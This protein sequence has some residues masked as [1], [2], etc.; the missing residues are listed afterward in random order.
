MNN[1]T[2]Y[3]TMTRN[4][5]RDLQNERQC[6]P[7]WHLIH[8]AALIERARSGAMSM[9]VERGGDE[10]PDAIVSLGGK[11][12]PLEAKLLTRCEEEERFARMARAI[13]NRVA[14]FRC[15]FSS[16]CSYG[17]NALDWFCQPRR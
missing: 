4:V 2:G 3:R 14:P 15:K 9:F 1:Q 17:S 8:T 12:V 5:L 7:A 10:R 13:E 16:S 6:L 11:N